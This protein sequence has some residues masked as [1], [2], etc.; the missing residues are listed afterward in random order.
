LVWGEAKK[1]LEMHVRV[2]IGVVIM[3]GNIKTKL[4]IN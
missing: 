3:E 4:G 1:T 2:E